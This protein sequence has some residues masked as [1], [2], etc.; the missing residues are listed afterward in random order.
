M[1][2]T[3]RTFRGV[4]DAHACDLRVVRPEAAGLA[5]Q[6][7]DGLG[8]RI[9]HSASVASQIELVVP[10]VEPEW[11]SAL[12]DAAWL[13]DVGYSTTVSATGFH[14]LD[15]AR[16]LRDHG[17]PMRTCRLVAWHTEPL[18]EARLLG[19]D[20]ELKTDFDRPPRR[21]SA[22]LAWADLTSS[23]GG[24]R[25]DVEQR[26]AEIFERYPPGSL[27]HDA[28]RASLPALRTAVQQVEELLLDSNIGQPASAMHHPGAS[29]D[30]T[31]PR[32]APVSV[33]RTR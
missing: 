26:L 3:S 2:P 13:H 32:G 30:R 7:L 6:L 22:A 12:K 31:P 24:R 27:V 20:E 11:R 28:V 29:D 10:L 5:A 9:L 15:G 1:T 25:W 8:T 21:A 17:W 19:L 14:P 4:T 33:P 16:W 23:P 18:E